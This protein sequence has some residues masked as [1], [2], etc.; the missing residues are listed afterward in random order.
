MFERVGGIFLL[1]GKRSPLRIFVLYRNSRLA[2]LD[3]S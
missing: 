2:F 3:V 1:K